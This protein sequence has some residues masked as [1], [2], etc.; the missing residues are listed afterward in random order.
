[1]SVLIGY[2]CSHRFSVVL[3]GSYRF[4]VVL[5]GSQC[6]SVG[7]VGL[8]GSQVFNGSCRILMVLSGFRSVSVV[9]CC[10]HWFS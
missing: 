5:L 1:M 2:Q 7:L 10:S 9:L 4:S 6:F 3:S 8:V